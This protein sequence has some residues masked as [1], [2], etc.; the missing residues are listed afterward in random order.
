MLCITTPEQLSEINTTYGTDRLLLCNF[1]GAE[2]TAALKQRGVTHIAAV[3]E[4]FVL[5]GSEHFAFWNK[6]ITD[7][8]H[9]GWF[10]KY[11]YD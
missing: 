9:A 7:D 8:E 5:N 11:K 10:D 1:K 4:E 3:G 6:D 2:D